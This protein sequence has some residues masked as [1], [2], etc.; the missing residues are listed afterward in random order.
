MN[1]NWTGVFDIVVKYLPALISMAE[2]LFSW[3]EKSGADKKTFVLGTLKTVTAGIVAESTGGQ[4]ET[5]AKIGPGV[6]MALEGLV[7]VA[8]ESGVF[9]KTPE[10]VN[11][12]IS[13]G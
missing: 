1:K 4:A 11:A 12:A 3:K 13:M 10:D 5:W 8:K 7:S 2:G 6:D 9:E